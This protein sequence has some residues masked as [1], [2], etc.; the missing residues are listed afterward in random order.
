[1]ASNP[2]MA[3]R[4]RVEYDGQC[5]AHAIVLGGGDRIDWPH[6]VYPDD[7]DGTQ[8]REVEEVVNV[9]AAAPDLLAACEAAMAYETHDDECGAHYCDEHQRLHEAWTVMASDAMRKARGE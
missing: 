2:Y 1:M 4:W 8:F 5:G 6:C 7:G 9:M 3:E